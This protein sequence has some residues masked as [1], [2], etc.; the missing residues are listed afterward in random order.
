MHRALRL[1]LTG[2][3]ALLAGCAG[4]P[5][6]P[7]VLSLQARADAVLNEVH[8]GSDFAGAVVLMRDGQVVYEKAVGLAQ[9]DPDR[10][11]TTRTPSDGGSLAKTL[12]AAAVWELVAEGRLSLDD[13]VT[14]HVPEYPYPGHTVRQLVTHRDGLPNYGVFDADFAPGQV[15]DTVDLL[16]ATPKRQP[17]PVFAPGV[18]VEY[19]DL[20]FDAAALVVERVTGRPIEAWWRERYFAPLAL[21]GMFA[22]P[23]RFA[24]W[25]V[26]RTVGYQRKGGGWVPF[27]AYDGEA[28]IG[29]AN[30]HASAHDWAR[31]GDGFARGHVMPAA[32]LEAG[33]R[34]PMLDSGLGNHLTLL[35]LYC[36]AGRQRCHYT[37]IYNGYYAQ[38]YWDRARRE[39]VAFV[40]NST[41]APWRRARL[42]R[43]LVD[44]LAGRAPAPEATP[45]LSPILK[46]DRSRFAG[47]YQS[48]AIGLLVIDVDGDCRS[49]LRVNGGE[50]VSL[51]ALPEGVFYAPMLEL[52]LGFTGAP[53]APTLHLRS[54]FHM[55]EAR[56]LQAPGSATP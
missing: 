39:V 34:E 5:A 10:P 40:S 26:P 28:H 4:V 14:R 19:S 38:V 48:A 30:V 46:A 20:G 31:W 6:M 18:Q 17:Q 7:P 29:G 53:A 35:G 25:P 15:R 21:Q 23:A 41:L 22:R 42:T 12:T 45:V 55:A 11:F 36:D 27:D 44:V 16:R 13:R 51:F 1:F 43:D 3:A 9:R 2:L 56:R 52:W 8:T 49:F 33:L 24:D 47:A 54:V 32:R 37:G 50:R